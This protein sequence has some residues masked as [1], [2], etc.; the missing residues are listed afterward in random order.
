MYHNFCWKN[1][2]GVYIVYIVH[3]SLSENHNNLRSIPNHNMI[4]SQHNVHNKHKHKKF[5]PY[6]TWVQ[7][8][9]SISPAQV[10]FYMRWLSTRVGYAQTEFCKY[11]LMPNWFYIQRHFQTLRHVN[12]ARNVKW[13]LKQQIFFFQLLMEHKLHYIKHNQQ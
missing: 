12:S 9:I 2:I 3:I 7:F 4:N 13:I 10:S 8:H 11:S 5:A 6:P 1:E